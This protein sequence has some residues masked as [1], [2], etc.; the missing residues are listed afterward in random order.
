MVMELVFSSIIMLPYCKS[1]WQNTTCWW[2]CESSFSNIEISSSIVSKQKALASSGEAKLLAACRHF[3]HCEKIK[4]KLLHL[5]L[6]WRTNNVG[7][8]ITSLWLRY[9]QLNLQL[10][11]KRKFCIR[12]QT[13]RN[14]S[15]RRTFFGPGIS[16]SWNSFILD[17][18]RADVFGSRR[19][20]ADSV[21][22]HKW[23]R[24]II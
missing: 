14:L 11:A 21:W 17:A 6:N 22:N 18:I 16:R 19:S 4:I 23:R 3:L 8:K 9:M 13:Y 15:H 1:L 7:A 24:Q 5:E 12:G 20:D 2:A 10:S